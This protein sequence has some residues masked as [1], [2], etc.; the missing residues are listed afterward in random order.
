MRL[1]RSHL[2]VAQLIKYTIHLCL[3]DGHGVLQGLDAI[4]SLVQGNSVVIKPLLHLHKLLVDVLIPRHQLS[5]GIV[6]HRPHPLR[7]CHGSNFFAPS[8]ITTKDSFFHLLF[9]VDSLSPSYH[10]GQ[11]GLFY[12]CGFQQDT[13]AIG[14]RTRLRDSVEYQEKEGHSPDSLQT[15][16]APPPQRY[17][18]AIFL[19]LPLPPLVSRS[20]TQ[21][22]DEKERG[23]ATT[24]E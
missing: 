9:S 17:G 12:L 2:T 14:R 8:F 16:A 6:E 4:F 24:R 15:I 21:S 22:Q 23:E 3:L 5:K 1:Y 10:H 13:R 7:L 18:A 19:S 20:D 11:N